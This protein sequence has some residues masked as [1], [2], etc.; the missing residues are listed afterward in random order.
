MPNRI[1]IDYPHQR[2][3]F[4]PIARFEHSKISA[5]VCVEEKNIPSKESCTGRQRIEEMKR[6]NNSK[7]SG[8][9]GSSRKPERKNKWVNNMGNFYCHNM[10]STT[11][12]LIYQL[13]TDVPVFGIDYG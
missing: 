10:E 11:T 12:S 7:V 4:F 3:R 8:L 13:L 5:L 2:I 9:T 1:Q 6:K